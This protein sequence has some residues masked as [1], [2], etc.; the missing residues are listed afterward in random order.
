LL[1]VSED[2]GEGSKV[3]WKWGKG[4]IY[5]RMSITWKYAGLLQHVLS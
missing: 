3:F 5:V 4:W 1:V 2:R